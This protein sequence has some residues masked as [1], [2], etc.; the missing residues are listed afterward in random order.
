[1]DVRN[2]GG[3]AGEEVVQLFLRQPDSKL[4]RPAKEL[5]GFRRIALEPGQTRTVDLP[6]TSAALAHWDMN[7][8]AFAID[9]R[10]LEIMV[11]SSS[12]D[13]RL[14]KTIGVE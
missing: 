10:S 8:H 11:G 3:R 7:R 1:V 4:E 5:R 2:T 9:G 13:I 12:A 6:L 14:K